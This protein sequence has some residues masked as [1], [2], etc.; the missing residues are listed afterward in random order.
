LPVE[1][2][3]IFIGQLDMLELVYAYGYVIGLVNEYIDCHQDGVSIQP[4][5]T[6][7]VAFLFVL[8]H[9]VEPVLRTDAAEDPG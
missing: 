1:P 8:Y 3:S 7:I 6:I 9:R 2:L 5:T 4:H